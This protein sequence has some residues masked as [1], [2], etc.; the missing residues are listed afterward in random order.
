MAG[1]NGPRFCQGGRYKGKAGNGT[2]VVVGVFVKARN[3]S[4]RSLS[5]LYWGWIRQVVAEEGVV[6][7]QSGSE[8]DRL[9]ERQ[10]KKLASALRARAKKIRTGV[11]PRNAS[12]YVRRLDSRWLPKVEEKAGAVSADFDDPDSMDLT[13]SFFGSSGGVTLRY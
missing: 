8:T 5:Y 9:S 6:L 2:V 1:S 4:S 13:A 12:S 10:A 7:P 3:G 11:A